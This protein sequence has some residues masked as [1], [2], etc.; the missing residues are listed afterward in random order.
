MTDTRALDAMMGKLAQSVHGSIA[1]ALVPIEER[2]LAV[3]QREPIAGKD[4]RDGEKG[5][6]GEI[7][8]QGEVG[9]IGLQGEIGEKGETGAQG[10]QGIPGEPGSEGQPGEKGLD[11]R[12]GIDGRDASMVLVSADLAEEV[13]K[14]VQFLNEAPPVIFQKNNVDFQQRSIPQKPVGIERDGNGGYRLIYEGAQ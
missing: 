2:L 6:A 11:G 10:D 1:K 5:E 9:P 3:E 4:G 8:P 13:A 12:D 7:G 14:A